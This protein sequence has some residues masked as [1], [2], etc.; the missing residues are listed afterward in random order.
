VALPF[1]SRAVLAAVYRRAALVLQPSEAEGFGLPVVEALACGTSMLASDL[2]V[3]REV[4]GDAVVYRPVG[5]VPAWAEA[6]LGLLDERRRSADAW[7]A[8]RDAG[9]ARARLY[10]WSNHVDR[11][12]AIYHDVL[13]RLPS[14]GR[15]LTRPNPLV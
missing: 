6:A 5:D 1:L 10:S 13:S 14:D 3:L 15:T 7:H 11:L 8:R 9:L 2:G 12:T 4:G